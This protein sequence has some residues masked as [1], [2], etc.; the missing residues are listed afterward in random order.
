METDKVVQ[1]HWIGILG[2]RMFQYAAIDPAI[3]WR[4]MNMIAEG[5][6]TKKAIA[7]KYDIDPSTI[8]SWERKAEKQGVRV[9]PDDQ[10][11]SNTC[12]RP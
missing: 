2:N 11:G 12:G 5:G 3:R 7:E 10:L 9:G 4:V 1:L 8:T 6:H